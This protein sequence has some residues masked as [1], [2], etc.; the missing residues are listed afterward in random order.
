MQIIKNA[1][2]SIKPSRNKLIAPIEKKLQSINY[3]NMNATKA[4]QILIEMIVLG[5]IYML[6]CYCFFSGIWY[7]NMLIVIS[8]LIFLYI[9]LDF[10]IE[11]IKK[12][13][14]KDVPKTTRKLRYY[15]I[16]TKNV[17]VALAKTE[18]KAPETTKIFIS[19]L[20]EAVES[21]DFKTNI[22]KIKDSSNTEWMKII[23]TLIESYKLYGDE[24]NVITKN[25]KKTTK[26]IEFIN[27]QQGLDNSALL[28]FQIFIF[29]LPLIAIPG[30][31]LFN[32][33][34]MIAF[35]QSQI[36]GN[37]EGQIMIGQIIFVS[38]IFTLLLSWIRKNN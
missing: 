21:E 24:E 4:I 28:G 29:F 23:C 31:Q 7:L 20:K 10:R 12:K 35:E 1:V 33:R 6:Y 30:I 11:W 34:L 8:T 2:E 19:K 38:N 32:Q 37:L 36:L 18:E 5:F 9:Y 14:N 17:E 13:V 27:L 3:S 15:L 26:T 25:L 22:K 16:N